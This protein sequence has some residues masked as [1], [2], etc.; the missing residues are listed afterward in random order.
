[1]SSQNFT[2]I[3]KLS[4]PVLI[5]GHTGFKG[6]W[7]TALLERLG[8]EVVGYSLAPIKDSLY[9]NLNRSKVIHETYSDLRNFSDLSRFVESTKPSLVFHLAAQPLVLDSYEFPRETFEV[10]LMGTVN[11]LEAC[12]KQDQLKAILVATT[13]KVY[14]NKN[15]SLKFK[16]NDELCGKDPYS[17]SKVAAENALI[18]YSNLRNTSSRSN[19][20]ALRSGNVIGGGDVSKNR[21]IPDLVQAFKRSE[22][23]L[24]RNPESTRPWQHVLDPLFGYL[25]AAESTID[26][27]NLKAVNFGPTSDSLSVKTVSELAKSTWGEGASLETENTK[28][29]FEAKTLELDSSYAQQVL[30]WSPKWSQEKAVID[31]IKW[32]KDVLKNG[33]TYEEVVNRDLDFLF[34]SK[35]R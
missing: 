4:G 15:N 13:D 14:S 24:I 9:Y 35:I 29:Y 3:N 20:V 11:L 18:A 1:V 2:N 6:M 12:K 10:N 31:S 28:D 19:I 23:A 25:L 5:T 33:C 8:V 27:N 21:L 7:L 34:E 30:G 26:G 32:W 16:E 17:A 22:P